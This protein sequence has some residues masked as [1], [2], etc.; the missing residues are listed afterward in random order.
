MIHVSY[1][2]VECLNKV[3]EIMNNPDK[4]AYIGRIGGSDTDVIKK[5]L[6]KGISRVSKDQI[7]ILCQ[8]NGYFDKKSRYNKSN[9]KKFSDLYIKACDSMDFTTIC[10]STWIYKV[11]EKK[12]E[13]CYNLELLGVRPSTY[14]CN[15]S[16]IE[17]VYPFLGAF[18]TFG[19]MKKILIISPFAKSIQYQ[20]QKTRINHLINDYTFPECSI[21]TYNTP[22]TY[23]HT[24]N[25]SYFNMVTEGYTD[26]FELAEKMF[27]DIS[28]ID[29]DIAFLSCASYSMYLGHKIKTTLNK[30]SIY[31]GGSL[32]MLFNIYGNRYDAVFKSGKIINPEYTIQALELKEYQQIKI[33]PNSFDGI[34]AYIGTK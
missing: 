34:L 13:Y 6:E 30:K 19:H 8:L 14:I 25:D 10:T 12:S 16:L 2:S 11:L 18:K 5:Y 17:S 20:V 23:N 7:D 31:I 33:G 32:N 24:D 26:W 3:I 27:N 1:D 28:K 29:F 22:I 21:I 9:I 15:Y 4:G